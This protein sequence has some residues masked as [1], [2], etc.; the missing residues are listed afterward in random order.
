MAANSDAAVAPSRK[1]C[2]V[3]TVAEMKLKNEKIVMLT[4]YDASFARL[5]D[6]CGIDIILVGDS[7]GMVV[8]GHTSTLP[9]T[10][11]EIAY[12]TACVARGIRST[13]VVSDLPFASYGTPDQAFNHAAQLMRAGAEM[14]KVEGGEWLADT[15]HHLVERGIPVCGH[16]GLTPQAVH[17]LGGFKVQGKNTDSAERLLS[18]AIALEQAGAAMVVLEAIPAALGKSVTQS[19]RI[20]TIG[21]GAGI[22][23]SGQVLVLHDMLGIYPGHRPKFVHDF[24]QGQPDIRSAITAY[25]EAVK[26]SQFPS[27]EH[28][29]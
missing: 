8:Q 27:A 24:M 9:V 16:L 17:Q 10:V 3:L 26:S 19:L 25:R 23:C 5:I 12:H 20:P 4:G 28:S 15:V 6:D 7:V 14:I 11:E 1:K 13:M 18:D 29:F 22:D 2:T 21:I